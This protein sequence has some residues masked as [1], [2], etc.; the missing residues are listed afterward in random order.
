MAT[1]HSPLRLFAWCDAPTAPTGFGR[2]AKHVLHALHDAGYAITQLAVN[3]DP[4]TLKDIPWTVHAPSNR[5]GD[6]YG[7]ADLQLLLQSQRF[8]LMWTTFDPEVPW[9]YKLPG[10]EQSAVS[11]LQSLRALNPG[12]RMLGWFPVDGGPLSDLELA[13]LG[14]SPMFDLAATMSPHVH[15][16]IAWTMKLRGRVPE[17]QHIDMDR[18][19]QILP[20][21]PHGVDL[22]SYRI[23]TPEEKAEAK[24]RMGIDPEQF[25]VLQ[26]ERNQ[27]R[28][29][30]YL[31]L[32]VMEQ[33][34]K[35]GH[36]PERVTLYQH[37]VPDE[38][39]AGCN[40][41]F[42][43][44]ELAWR[45]GLTPGEDVRWPG[46]FVSEKDMV[47]TVYAAGDAFLS[48]ST[49][50]GFQYPAWEALACGI[51][52]VLPKDS[53]REAWFG[54]KHAPNVH[55]YEV[56]KHRL[57]MR[58]GYARRMSFAKP[59]AAARIIGKMLDGRQKF[60]PKSEAG[61]SWVARH[62]D[63]KAVQEKWVELVNQEAAT[64]VQERQAE[65]ICMPGEG[66]PDGT[67]YI[68]MLHNPG[69]GD[70]VMAGPALRAL[71]ASGARVRLE[72]GRPQL[73]LAKVMD[74]ADEY[75][76]AHSP[77]GAMLYEHE[78]TH[79]HELWRPVRTEDWTSTELPRH[80]TIARHLGVPA[81]ELE[82]FAVSAPEALTVQADARFREEFGVDPANCVVVSLQSGS[83]QREL[84]DSTLRQLLPHL[85]AMELTPVLVGTR[86]V[87]ERKVG[88]INLTGQTE[89]PV[90][91]ALLGSVAAVVS[92]DNGL[93]H[94]AAAQGTPLVVA[95]TLFHPSTRFWHYAGKVHH[96]LPRE[97]TGAAVGEEF[98]AGVYTKAAPG[99]WASGI[100]VS[101]IASEL[102]AA[103]GMDEAEA[104][105]PALVLPK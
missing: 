24:R 5:N 9:R 26:V 19:A 23:P 62:A 39:N 104:A 18:V 93:A 46:G 89:L 27:Q 17:G 10:T 38:E 3:L 50:E 71:R 72:V 99:L 84:P 105:A 6:P 69:H 32:E 40:L 20:V 97:G 13:A 8:D 33:L 12:F 56:D 65:G 91:A 14:G 4:A 102:R 49:G 98:P 54:R 76:P 15:D 57:V 68:T 2:S 21:I 42:N 59:E 36:G 51:P 44:P 73:G 80:E 28:K 48:V 94:I 35:M 16:L 45:Y 86:P 77:A 87:E 22:E 52:L 103:L 67:R 101:E 47:E 82:P 61:R 85:R 88:V 63:V 70:M 30:N 92:V 79:L 53:A 100:S 37:M 75:V 81:D 31:G 64:L 55:L 34:R 11:A 96:V 58:G 43:L 29:Q 25:V 7:L 74:L 1:P 95:C 83:P 41:G 60:A 66:L 90:L 78:V